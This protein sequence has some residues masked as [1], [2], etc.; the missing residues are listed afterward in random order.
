M[1]LR[2][3]AE[4]SFELV[5]NSLVLDELRFGEVSRSSEHSVGSI[6][7][8]ANAGMRQSEPPAEL[9]RSVFRLPP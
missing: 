9:R 3:L 8:V 2:V 7:L 4:P 6:E 5:Q 1:L